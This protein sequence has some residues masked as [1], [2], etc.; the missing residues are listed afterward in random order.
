[1]GMDRKRLDRCL[2]TGRRV[3]RVQSDMAEAQR[4]G[5]KGTPA[6]FVNGCELKGGAVPYDV[7]AN[8]IDKELSQTKGSR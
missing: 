8:A 4:V 1:M 7:V 2:D 5:V 3:E 6:I